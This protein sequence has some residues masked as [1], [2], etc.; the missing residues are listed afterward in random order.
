MFPNGNY[1]GCSLSFKERFFRPFGARASPDLSTQFAVSPCASR[2]SVPGYLFAS[3]AKASRFSARARLIELSIPVD[4]TEKCRPFRDSL[5]FTY[6]YPGLTSGANECRRFW[7]LACRY[8]SQS[9]RPID[10]DPPCLGLKPR[11]IVSPKAVTSNAALK[12]RSST[13]LPG[14]ERAAAWV[15]KSFAKYPPIQKPEGSG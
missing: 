6:T 13:V 4:L 10:P 12:R 3:S 8:S 15:R 5:P 14:S 9:L 11:I 1:S 7:R 2:L